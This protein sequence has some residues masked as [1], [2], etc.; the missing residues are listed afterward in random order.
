MHH[1]NDSPEKGFIIAIE[2]TVY[3]YT[4]GVRVRFQ[5]VG[6]EAPIPF[7]LLIE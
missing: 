5:D 3:K 2:W 1:E 4:F 7:A 6:H